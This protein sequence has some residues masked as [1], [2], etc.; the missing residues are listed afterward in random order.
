[1]QLHRLAEETAVRV[2]SHNTVLKT[3]RALHA[4]MSLT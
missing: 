2:T 3:L 4:A 1:M